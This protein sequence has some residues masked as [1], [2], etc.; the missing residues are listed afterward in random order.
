MGVQSLAST[1]KNAVDTRIKREA[2]ALRGTIE[3][4][5]FQCGNKSYP[6]K[7]AVDCNVSNGRRVWAQLSSNGT[8]VIVGA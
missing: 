2:R 5:M 6:F 4:G 7:Q 1:L 8:A 3:N